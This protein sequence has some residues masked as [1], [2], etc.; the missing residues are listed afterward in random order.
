MSAERYMVKDEYAHC[1]K[2]VYADEGYHGIS[3]DHYS[4]QSSIFERF[5]ESTKNLNALLD[6][7]GVKRKRKN[8]SEGEG[9][10]A[11]KC[12]KLATEAF[13]RETGGKVTSALIWN[14]KGVYR[15]PKWDLARWGVDFDFTLEGSEHIFH[16]SIASWS[17]MTA[18][19]KLKVMTISPGSMAYTYED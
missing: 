1:K 3:K 6:D 18:V 7:F 14:Q 4:C 13:E 16:G 2:P 17:T 15:G 10:A 5:E 11:Q 12:I 9:K 19:S 8:A